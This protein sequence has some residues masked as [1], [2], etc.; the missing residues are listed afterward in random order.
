M[1]THLTAH[2]TTVTELNEGDEGE[3]VIAQT[4]FYPE[5]GGQVGD[6]GII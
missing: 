3:I 4:P 5:G 6:H 2:D 1:V